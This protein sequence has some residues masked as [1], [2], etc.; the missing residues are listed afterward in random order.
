MSPGELG[1]QL[2]RT[3]FIPLRLH[4]VSGKTVDIRIPGIAWLLG[5]GL[6]VFR[7]PRPMRAAAE[8]YDVISLRQIEK[9][10][11]LNGRPGAGRSR[12]RGT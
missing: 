2:S 9:I 6:L 4:L 12:R 7:S 8:G 10:E 1:D 3:P 11:Q 5:F